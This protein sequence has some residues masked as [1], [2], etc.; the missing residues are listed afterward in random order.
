[1]VVNVMNIAKPAEGEQALLT[2]DEV[3]T[4][5]HEFGHA[6]HGLLSDVHYPS[7]S[8][9][10]VPRDFVEFPSQINE[11]WLEPE[12]LAHYA[13]HVETG[14]PSPS[15]LLPFVRNPSGGRGLLPRSTLP[16]AGWIWLGTLSS[17]DAEKI[18]DVEEFEANAL[19]QAGVDMEGRIAPRYRSAYFNHIFA[20]GYS[21]GYWSYLWA[22]VLDAD[23]FQA[24]I[25]TGAARGEG[26]DEGTQNSEPLDLGDVRAAGDRFRRMILSAVRRLTT[27][28]PFGCSAV[29]RNPCNHCFAVVDWM[30]HKNGCILGLV[31]QRT[32][33]DSNT[34]GDLV[35]SHSQRGSGC[36]NYQGHAGDHSAVGG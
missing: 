9:T 25:D 5:F 13:R 22:E 21:A 33:V 2:I 27:R 26:D 12:I 34:V 20:G 16:P 1:M 6:L 31:V 18:T 30:A 7:L 19:Q 32:G 3:T 35:P 23:G 10:S 15:S 17:D 28:T 29:S 4:V 14:R 8:G 11:N 24:F 36:G